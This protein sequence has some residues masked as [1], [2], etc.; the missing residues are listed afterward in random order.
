MLE[1]E[2][3]R[4]RERGRGGREG[5]R[6]GEMK[7]KRVALH[8]QYR[9]NVLNVECTPLTHTCTWHYVYTLSCIAIS[10]TWLQPPYIGT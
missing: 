10:S 4:E 8:Y 2:R 9:N 3:E 1:S 7:E 5:G 6:E